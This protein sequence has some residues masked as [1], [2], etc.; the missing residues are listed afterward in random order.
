M[1]GD[2][3]LNALPTRSPRGCLLLQTAI[4]QH[5]ILIIFNS[6]AYTFHNGNDPDSIPEARRSTTD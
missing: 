4:V 3:H 6:N 5:A 1:A 2:S